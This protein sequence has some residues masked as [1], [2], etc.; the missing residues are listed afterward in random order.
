MTDAVR[1]SIAGDK[2]VF[3]LIA[4]PN[5]ASKS[6]FSEKRL[7]PLGLT[8]IDPDAVAK[9]LFGRFVQN[10]DEAVQAT[11]E[12]SLRARK[13]LLE[14][15]SIALESVFSDSK[16]YKLGLLEEARRAGFK[17]VLVFIGVDSP[18]IC[19]ARVQDRVNRG[20]HDVPDNV[21]RDRFP[22]CFAN[23][24]KALAR[25]DM[26]LLIDNSGCYGPEIQVD[27]SRHYMFGLVE[28]S[29][30]AEIMEPVPNWFTRFGIADVI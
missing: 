28:A 1:R 23:L 25:I 27:G 13:H 24:R 5:G 8:C 26:A 2:P 4:G 21:I 17:T 29:L 12:A 7:K 18:E 16:G 6:T 30:H 3:L 11:V 15:R 10:R 9:E 20:G 22:R 19:I 14:G